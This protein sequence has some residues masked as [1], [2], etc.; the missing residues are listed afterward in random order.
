[1]NQDTHCISSSWGNDSI[2]LLGWWLDTGRAPCYVTYIDTGWASDVWL[3]R[4]DRAS[5]WA[6]AQGFD[7]HTVAAARGFEDECVKNKMIPSGVAKWCTRILKQEPWLR[8]ADKI[9]PDAEMTCV[10]GV[11]REES[12]K[13]AAWPEHTPDSDRHGGRDL[14][15]PLVRMREPE[16]DQVLR[17]HGWDPLPHRSM[18]C[19]PCIYAN[20]SDMLLIPAERLARMGDLERRVSDAAGKPVRFFG[21]Q[22][23]AERM[24]WAMSPR[25][26]HHT[27]Q[28]SLMGNDC[29]SGWCGS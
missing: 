10:V 13:R 26:R 20:R 17:R 18:E 4:H 27:D 7:V 8:W 9:D 28:L 24:R 3:D 11:R 6:R 12:A 2:A 19:S 16:R 21:Q 15:A 25:G 1:M 5:E 14:W 29:D 22:T 23:A